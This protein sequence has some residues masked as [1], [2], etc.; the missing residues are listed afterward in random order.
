MEAFGVSST[1]FEN[2]IEIASISKS[3]KFFLINASIKVE[4]TPPL[5]AMPNFFMLNFSMLFF[6]LLEIRFSIKSRFRFTSTVT[7]SFHDFFG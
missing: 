5:S 1:L 4:S 3:G 6:I 7:K 2:L